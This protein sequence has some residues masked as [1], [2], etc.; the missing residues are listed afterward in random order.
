M[1]NKTEVRESV[2]DGLFQSNCLEVRILF[3]LSTLGRVSTNYLLW[4]TVET[5]E[6]MDLYKD[7]LASVL[8]DYKKPTLVQQRAIKPCINEHD[9][10][11]EAPS[12]WYLYFYFRFLSRH[13]T[14]IF[15]S[16]SGKTT[17]VAISLLQ[18]IKIQ[19]KECQA[20]VLVPDSKTALRVSEFDLNLIHCMH[21]H[22]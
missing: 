11:I 4:Q 5:F 13:F 22:H 12:G 8:Y 15:F 19:T 10:I 14:W 16:G 18:L 7:L 21:R 2:E 1:G 6:E 20:L 17:A 3:Y 9:V